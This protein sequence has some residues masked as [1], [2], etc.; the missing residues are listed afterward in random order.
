M[1]DSLLCANLRSLKP[2]I[3]KFHDVIWQTTSRMFQK[4][5]PLDY[6]SSF[7]QSDH[8]FLAMSSP[9]PSCYEARSAELV[10]IISYPSSPSRI[11]V[12]LLKPQRYV[13]ENRNKLRRVKERNTA[14]EKTERKVNYLSIKCTKQKQSV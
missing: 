10:V 13:I 6:F 7:N 5:A 12:S 2:Y 3:W 9:L 11:I 1:K 8:C 4:C 14:S